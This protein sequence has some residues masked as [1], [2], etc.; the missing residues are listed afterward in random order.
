M[1]EEGG[2]EEDPYGEFTHKVDPSAITPGGDPDE[3]FVG[4]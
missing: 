1:D 3:D 4:S 2:K